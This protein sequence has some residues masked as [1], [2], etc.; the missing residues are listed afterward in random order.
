MSHFGLPES[1]YRKQMAPLR[2]GEVVK[3]AREKDIPV[4]SSSTIGSVVQILM[5]KLDVSLVALK[6][7][8]CR[9]PYRRRPRFSTDATVAIRNGRRWFE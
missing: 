2:K 6:R 7:I 1:E 5:E 9:P 4:G 8:I 3:F